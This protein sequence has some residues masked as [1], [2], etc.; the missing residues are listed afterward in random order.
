VVGGECSKYISIESVAVSG[1][2]QESMSVRI[3]QVSVSKD[4][5]HLLSMGTKI[6]HGVNV[7]RGV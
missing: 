3:S 4:S 6:Q 2:S 5:A 7:V 1:V